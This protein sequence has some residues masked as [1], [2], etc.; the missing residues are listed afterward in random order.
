MAQLINADFSRPAVALFAD[1]EWVPSPMPGVDR[2]MLD[3]VGDEVARA[4]SLVRYAPNSVFPEHAHGG[5]E[6]I[7][8][9]HGEFAD[10]HGRYPAGSYLRNPVGTRHCPSVGAQ[11]AMLFVKLRQFDPL[12]QRQCV[13]DTRQPAWLPT[14]DAGA[15]VMPLHSYGP[16][17]VR[18]VRLAPGKGL[19]T[20]PEQGGLELLVLEGELHGEGQQLIRH[21]WL[22]W[23]PQTQPVL[24]AGD[25]G[26]L[27]YLK[28]GHLLSAAS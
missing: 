12:D 24:T 6:E 23:P 10:E 17:Q 25:D 16:E 2:M 27:L 7:V 4:T 9:L 3:R 18:L 13:V 1:G 5:G 15:E 22:R 26:A 11:G 21:D 19:G 20:G 8:V 14:R 28:S